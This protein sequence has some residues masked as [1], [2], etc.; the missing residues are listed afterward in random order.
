MKYPSD[1]NS[2]QK[3]GNDG[4]YGRYRGIVRGGIICGL[5]AAAIL[6]TG[7]AHVRH[8]FYMGRIPDVA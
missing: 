7:C 6:S 8:P 3:T 5:L 1:H 4:S 2:D